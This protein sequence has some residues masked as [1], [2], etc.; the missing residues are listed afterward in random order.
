MKGKPMLRSNLLFAILCVAAATPAIGLAQSQPASKTLTPEQQRFQKIV[1][2]VAGT[3][4]LQLDS[5]N[6]AF[7]RVCVAAGKLKSEPGIK[8]FSSEAIG[9]RSTFNAV[10]HSAG[11]HAWVQRMFRQHV[12]SLDAL[13]QVIKIEGKK[14]HEE[15]VGHTNQLLIDLKADVPIDPATFEYPEVDTFGIET[16]IDKLT[17]GITKD[18][19]GALEKA[20]TTAGLSA[21]GGAIGTLAASDLARMNDG[22]VDF[23][24]GIGAFLFGIGTEIVLNETLNNSMEVTQSLERCLARTAD[25]IIGQCRSGAI[26]Q[27]IFSSYKKAMFEHRLQVLRA[28]ASEYQVDAEWMVDQVFDYQSTANVVS[29]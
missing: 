16:Q 23:F 22:E 13:K 15:L 19:G 27:A 21:A 18:V 26:Q 9:L 17:S 1:P 11:H 29:K 6:Q 25:S 14:L 4:Q 3:F 8:H 2:I 20:W 10:T 28:L 7:G 12:F 5:A 24:E